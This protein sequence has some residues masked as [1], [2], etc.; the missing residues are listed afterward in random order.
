MKKSC[1]VLVVFMLVLILVSLGGCNDSIKDNIPKNLSYAEF[2]VYCGQ[3]KN[4]FVEIA[5]GKRERPLKA[6]GYAKDVGDFCEVKL[7]PLKSLSVKSCVV[8]ISGENGTIEG[9]AKL[10]MTENEF[11]FTS[12][13][14]SKIGVMKTVTLKFGDVEE[15]VDLGDMLLDNIIWS[16]ALDIAK[17]EFQERLEADKSGAAR[18]IYVKLTKD[19]KA[20]GGNYFWYVCYVSEHGD[21]WSLLLDA[22]DGNVIARR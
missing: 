18:E 22:K 14:K 13:T 3:S 20:I 12:L 16:K 2:E 1:L 9:E 7:T 10:S 6:D 8:I 15:S 17:V 11:V 21:F 5:T 19:R 4:F